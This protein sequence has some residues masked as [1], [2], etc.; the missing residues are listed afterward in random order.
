MGYL[1][2]SQNKSFSMGPTRLISSVFR[3]IIIFLINLEVV[4]YN[5]CIKPL[6]LEI[7][8]IF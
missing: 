5:L 1:H 4:Y 2:R 8:T 6:N 7:K 3:I